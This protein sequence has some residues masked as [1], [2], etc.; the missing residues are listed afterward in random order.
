MDLLAHLRLPCDTGVMGEMDTQSVTKELTSSALKAAVLGYEMALRTEAAELRARMVAGR[1]SDLQDSLR[2]AEQALE[3]SEKQVNEFQGRAQDAEIRLRECQSQIGAL[4]DSA[5]K[6]V[7]ALGEVEAQV[8][9]AEERARAA[10]DKATTAIEKA[11][12]SLAEWQRMID[13]SNLAMKERVRL[14]NSLTEV[15]SELYAVKARCSTLDDKLNVVTRERSEW[16]A[17]HDKVALELKE[18]HS[19]IV[20]QGRTLERLKG[21]DEEADIAK[22][23]VSELEVD[24]ASRDTE[25]DKLRQELEGIRVASRRDQ[26]RMMQLEAEVA[27]TQKKL[28]DYVAGHSAAIERARAGAI[29]EFQV[30][31]SKDPAPSS[32]V[33][34]LHSVMGKHIDNGLATPE[35]LEFVRRQLLPTLNYGKYLMQKDIY[36]Q[37]RETLPGFNHKIYKLPRPMKHAEIAPGQQIRYSLTTQA[38]PAEAGEEVEQ[39]KK[40]KRKRKE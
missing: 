6:A 7:L 9:R 24:V 8:E 29:S 35:G 17:K 1:Q 40:K 16:E 21:Q 2:A 13:I 5:N 11:K 12:I 38:Q 3:A 33:N 10:E 22:A 25:L 26:A 36:D 32:V 34:W 19:Q 20:K 31:C 30:S 37:L 39:E 18:A 28:E 23:R 14:R 4:K 15:E 27:A